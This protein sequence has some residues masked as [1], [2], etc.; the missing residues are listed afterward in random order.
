V[1]NILKFAIIGCG[2]IAKKHA[3]ILTSD[4][5]QDCELVGVCDLNKAKAKDIADNFKTAF[6]TDMHLMMKTVVPDVVVILTES[7]LHPKITIALSIYGAHI[8]VEKPMALTLSDAD[9]MIAACD[10]G[11]IKLFVVK[12]NRFN[13]PI[14]KLRNAIERNYFG[15]IVS[16]SVR[17]RWCRPQKYY[18]QDKWRGTW[19]LDGGVL[20]NQASHHLDMILWMLGD[21]TEVF[22]Y[23]STMLANI[24]AEDTS[25]S[26]MKFKSGALATFE[27]TT[28]A[29]PTD[30][31]GSISILG[32][33]GYV[34]V[35]GFALNKMLDWKFVDEL[36]DS[37]DLE[38]Y[39]ENP[40]NVYGHGHLS[41]YQHVVESIR[42]GS[43]NLIDGLSARRTVEALNAMYLSAET[44][45]PISLGSGNASARLGR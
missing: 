34:H 24:E 9:K 22:T 11:N 33:N 7:G 5:L 12:Q 10:K 40:P 41:Y 43:P 29:R 30:I 2:R 32:E 28:C 1:N 35:G 20:A 3:Q 26:V 45:R 19:S 31:E 42:R 38:E 44:G 13:R 25:V 18:D 16:C 14:Q 8:I 27:A 6:F 37:L 23:T 4:Q 15:K 21:L 36:E 39:S 17:V